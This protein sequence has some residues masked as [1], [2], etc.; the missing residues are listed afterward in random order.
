MPLDLSD[1]ALGLPAQL[2]LSDEAL[3]LES[4]ESTESK[5]AR[6]RKDLFGSIRLPGQPEPSNEQVLRAME[7]RFNRPGEAS[8]AEEFR[9]LAEGAY[10]MLSSSYAAWKGIFKGTIAKTAGLSF[11]EVFREEFDSTMENAADAYKPL[12]PEGETLV[13]KTF[14]LLTQGIDSVGDFAFA[15][16]QLSTPFGMFRKPGQPLLTEADEAGGSPIA[17]AAAKTAATAALLIPAFRG[18]GKGKPGP[19]PIN[20]WEDFTTRYPESAKSIDA[21]SLGAVR[22]RREDTSISAAV[23][24]QLNTELGLTGEMANLPFRTKAAMVFGKVAPNIPLGERLQAVQ[25][26]EKK[27][28]TLD[29]LRIVMSQE[30]GLPAPSEIGRAHV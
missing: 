30:R 20:S 26:L 15:P 24:R 7:G 23:D 5:I 16:R 4:V 29:Q 13:A 27:I 28:A 22:F 21:S 11:G 9:A 8:I 19:Q 14:E 1:E 10:S 18:K 2:D 12:A 6:G 25:A 17:G 3:G